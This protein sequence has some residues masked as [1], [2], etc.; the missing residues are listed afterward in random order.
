[1]PVPPPGPTTASGTTPSGASESA[2]EVVRWA[3][4]SC[5]LVPVVLVAGGTS[6]G[7]AVTTAL[8]LT[9]VTAA[10]RALLRR[11][12]RLAARAPAEPYA[13]YRGRH[14]RTGTRTGTRAGAGAHRGGRRGGRCTP[15]D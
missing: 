13:P 4:F 3:A 6:P 14:S 5:A 2:S 11:S 15:A 9:A 8:G 12:E 10:C 1:M 7:G